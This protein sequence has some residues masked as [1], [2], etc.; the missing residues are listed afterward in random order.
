M[1]NIINKSS[2]SFI[3]NNVKP[4]QICTNQN[5]LMHQ[6]EYLDAHLVTS[7]VGVEWRTV[8]FL[9]R[10]YMLVEI[11]Y[12]KYTRASHDGQNMFS[13][14]ASITAA[15]KVMIASKHVFHKTRITAS[16]G[17]QHNSSIMEH[18]VLDIPNMFGS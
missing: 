15:E 18:V 13:S 7:K 14:S 5:T 10:C 2:R 17:T 12:F 6:S 8:L 9:F 11:C 3:V 4:I 16:E 1:N